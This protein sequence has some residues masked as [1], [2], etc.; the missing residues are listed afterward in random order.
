M[1]GGKGLDRLKDKLQAPLRFLYRL[2]RLMS[3]EL[4]NH[5]RL[6]IWHTWRAFKNGFF[7]FNYR[8]FGLETSGNPKDFV[9]D[10]ME[11]VKILAINGEYDAILRN[12]FVFPVLMEKYGMPTPKIHAVIRQGILYRT[13]TGMRQPWNVFAG[14]LIAD[15]KLVLKP[16]KGSHGYGVMVIQK[17]R[18]HFT[19]N[20]KRIERAELAKLISMFD[21]YMV[22]EFI[23]QCRHSADLY[24]DTVNTIRLVTCL[25]PKNGR[26]FIAGAV[27]RIGTSRSYPVDNFKGGR[28]GLSAPVD[29]KTG[30]LGQAA[31]ASEKFEVT[32]HKRHPETGAPI[33]GTTV[34]HWKEIKSG[35]ISLAE[36]LVT[37]PYIG[38]DVAPTEDGYCVIEA[39]STPGTSVMQ[40][41]GPLLTSEKLKQF[42]RFHKII[43]T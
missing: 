4:R 28:G 15:E 18:L 13:D 8:L 1:L 9:S 27:Q 12:K 5:V 29:L 30:R 6:S 36:K 32:W 19:V 35:I 14:S 41:H 10:Y 38:W 21:D 20:G 3:I 40:V 11:F 26:A 16:I 25:H 42:Y 39:N 2:A 23:A 7:T 34:H 43:K 17:G 37:A 24:P 33:E 22:S 31:S